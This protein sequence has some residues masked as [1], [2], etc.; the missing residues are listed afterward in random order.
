MRS[1]NKKDKHM[2]DLREKL[3]T[4]ENQQS[5]N[6]GGTRKSLRS[7]F[8]GLCAYCERSRNDV[9]PHPKGE[10]KF[11]CD[12]FRPRSKF[13]RLRYVAENLVYACHEC[14]GVKGDQWPDRV[15]GFIDP[16]C[17]SQ[18]EQPEHVFYYNF[19]WVFDSDFDVNVQGSVG[20]KVAIKQDLPIAVK[21]R[22]EITESAL[23]LNYPRHA[24]APGA[25]ARKERRDRE[26]LWGY[27]ESDTR[28][29]QLAKERYNHICALAR[30]LSSAQRDQRNGIVKKYIS[31]SASFSTMCKQFLQHPKKSEWIV[32]LASAELPSR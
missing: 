29:S 22:A 6:F 16:W 3:I 23:S 2:S 19:E 24:Q 21:S 25:L 27:P 32:K 31:P 20:I 12:H 11:Q 5:S 14:N 10:R 4:L 8:N 30:E 15:G 7:L 13:E 9:P 18:S 28:M 26:D 1:V 17:E